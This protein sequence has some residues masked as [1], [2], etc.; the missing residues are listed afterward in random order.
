MLQYA[1]KG[2]GIYWIMHKMGVMSSVVSIFK[3][4]NK[5]KFEVP[6][7]HTTIGS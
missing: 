6:I 5:S 1:N 4:V 3:L 7:L 2:F